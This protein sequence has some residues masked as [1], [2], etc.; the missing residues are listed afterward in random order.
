MI[1]LLR[2]SFFTAYSKASAMTLSQPNPARPYWAAG[3][4]SGK[5]CRDNASFARVRR[6]L[7]H[8]F[9]CSKLCTARSRVPPYL[10]LTGHHRLLGQHLH[11]RIPAAVQRPQ[12]VLDDAIF[13]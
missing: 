4:A 8:S 3:T 2:T 7:G 13:E 12:G 11:R 6:A 10:V 5:F 1:G 9:R